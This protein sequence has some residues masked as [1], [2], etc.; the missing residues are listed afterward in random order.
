MGFSSSKQ[1]TGFQAQQLPGLFG[2][3]RQF[4]PGREIGQQ[5]QSVLGGISP[6]SA[7]QQPFEQ[8]VLSPEFGPQSLAENELLNS[9]AALTQ[10]TSALRGLGPSTPGALAQS[11][12]PALIGLRQ[13]QVGNLQGGAQLDLARNQ[14]LIAGLLELAGLAIPQT[15]GGQ[16]GSGRSFSF[17]PPTI[18]LGLGGGGGGE[19]G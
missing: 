2:Q 7:F 3:G 5:L 17:T 8:S 10:G 1:S 11:L 14:Q 16:V 18:G 9:L 4:E 15:V 19:V 12:A 13:Q 6:E